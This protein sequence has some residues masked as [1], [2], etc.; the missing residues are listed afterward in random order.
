V[1]YNGCDKKRILHELSFNIHFYN[2]T[3][4]GV[5]VKGFYVL[6][7]NEAERSFSL[8]PLEMK[9]LLTFMF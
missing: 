2:T 4:Q 8:S 1:K 6:L 7:D 5:K 3:N 9:N